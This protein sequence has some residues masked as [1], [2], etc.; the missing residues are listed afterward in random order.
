MA[1][2][3]KIID[4]EKLYIDE[5][6][7]N[8]DLENE[9]FKLQDT[10]NKLSIELLELQSELNKYKFHCNE[11]ENKLKNNI[12]ITKKVTPNIKNKVKHMVASGMTYRDIAKQMDISIKTISRI[13]NGYYDK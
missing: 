7:K 6:D 13:M 3:K 8:K 12:F 4:Y 11:L 1:F 10:V 2:F 9:C 5:L